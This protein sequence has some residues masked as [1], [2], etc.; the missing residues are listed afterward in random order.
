LSQGS[1][2]SVF[3][4]VVYHFGYIK[5]SEYSFEIKK[6]EKFHHRHLVDIPRIKFCS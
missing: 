6:Y 1:F 5:K 3:M 4:H 2:S